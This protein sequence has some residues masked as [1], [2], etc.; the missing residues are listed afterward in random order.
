MKELNDLEREVLVSEL[1]KLNYLSKMDIQSG[2][3]REIPEYLIVSYV[4]MHESVATENLERAYPDLPSISLLLS[5]LQSDGLIIQSSNNYK[6][7]IHPDLLAKINETVTK[8]AGNV[9]RVP[10][11]IDDA[12]QELRKK[13]LN[14]LC[15]L[16]LNKGISI[17]R[18]GGNLLNV[19]EIEV[20]YKLWKNG[21]MSPEMLEQV[22]VNRESLSLVLSNL[23]ADGLIEQTPNYKWRI[24]SDLLEELEKSVNLFSVGTTSKENVLISS[25]DET[26][27][28]LTDLADLTELAKLVKVIQTHPSF[29]TLEIS[30][31]LVDD[32]FNILKVIM[33]EQPVSTDQILEKL[34]HDVPISMILSN[35]AADGLIVQDESSYSWQLGEELSVSLR[36]ITIS[37]DD[38]SQ[39]AEALEAQST[40]KNEQEMSLPSSDKP[41]ADEEPPHIGESSADVITEAEEK[42][43][44]SPEEPPDISASST[45]VLSE[46]ETETDEVTSEATSSQ[47][48]TSE[49]EPP[50]V[51]IEDLLKE[52]L[53]TM[54]FNFPADSGEFLVL[55]LLAEH[56]PLSGEKIS[57]MIASPVSISLILSN[58]V[59]DGLLKEE[60]Y[61]YELSPSLLAILNELKTPE[62][63]EEPEPEDES[64]P[65]PTEDEAPKI[66]EEE[67]AFRNA[68]TK[69]GYIKPDI[70]LEENVSYAIIKTIKDHPLIGQQGI[71]EKNPS[72]SPVL[73]TRTLTQLEIDNVI[74]QKSDDSWQLTQKISN[75]L[76]EDE[77]KVKEKI[78]KERRQKEEEEKQK[79]IEEN[80]ERLKQI[81]ESLKNDGLI[82][83][84]VAFNIDLLM[85]YPA[86]ELLALMN[87]FGY[88]QHSML[89]QKASSASPVLISR[90]IIQLTEKG[91][92]KSEDDLEFALTDKGK[93]VAN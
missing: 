5:N 92:L 75:I 64:P 42:S 70:P 66:D 20:V 91:Y 16:L 85:S 13:E 14:K 65:P 72:I 50:S 78:E 8:I 77:R 84:G 52:A 45:T 82:P 10:E 83:H 51:T 88:T 58:L 60:S 35:L 57:E 31:I 27:S 63:E 15:D 26:P 29:S 3:Y 23:Q 90:T 33:N 4:Y 89:K 7:E 46:E 6:W 80:K 32:S 81:Y 44:E 62:T 49:V 40:D 22:I 12:S 18:S 41:T 59:A 73:I 1:Q 74:E 71:K 47:V 36:K 56:A 87:L 38:V 17:D 61:L 55:K 67:H 68:L 43:M 30:Q 34:S 37:P 25:E 9:G 11:S 79:K 69:L 53:S 48:E 86:F 76:N 28:P 54:N 93:G 39:I 2:R 21:E 24:T 19:P